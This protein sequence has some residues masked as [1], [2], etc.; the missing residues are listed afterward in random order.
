VQ[1]T[2]SDDTNYHAATNGRTTMSSDPN[3]LDVAPHGLGGLWDDEVITTARV[4]REKVVVQRLI[5]RGA[6]GEV[7]AGTFNGHMV[8]IKMLLRGNRKSIRHLNAFLAEVKR[9]AVL[10]HPRIVRLV[11]VAWDS[12]TDLCAAL[13]YVEGGDLRAFLD[14]L[15][16]QGQRRGFDRGKVAIALHVAH[17][18]TYLH[19]LEMPMIHRD[20]K[21]PSRW[22]PSSRTSA[23]LENGSPRR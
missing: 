20:L 3:S 18:L 11:G 14:K 16:V 5:S 4:P 6:Y 2:A 22:R 1:G 8:A 10:D 21:S 12:L 15:Q 7:Y 23:C 17:A 13:E 9:T 19:S